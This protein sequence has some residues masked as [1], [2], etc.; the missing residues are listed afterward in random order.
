MSYNQPIDCNNCGNKIY[1]NKGDKRPFDSETEDYHK[2]SGFSPSYKGSYKPQTSP[3]P[4]QCKNGCGIEILYDAKEGYYREN[5]TGKRHFPCPAFGNKQQQTAK[6]E[7]V[8]NERQTFIDTTK[9]EP[10]ESLTDIERS[11]IIKSLQEQNTILQGIALQLTKINDILEVSTN[12][13]RATK[14]M[15]QEWMDE[16]KGELNK[17]TSV[18]FEN[19]RLLEQEITEEELADVDDESGEGGIAGFR[20]SDTGSKNIRN[21]I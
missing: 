11:V 17:R 5:A 18:S 1:W 16:V 3:K 12:Y 15:F 9:Q 2:C 20:P 10:V 14:N 13:Q 21:D 4:I 6:T 8:P 19:G 7:Y